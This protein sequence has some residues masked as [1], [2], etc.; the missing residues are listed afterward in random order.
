MAGE[1]NAVP[2]QLIP[3]A[4]TAMGLQGNHEGY[5]K[6]LLGVQDELQAAV[7]SPG[8]GNQIVAAM[9]DAHQ[10]GADLGRQLQEI[11]QT[12]LDTGIA[13]D[14]QDME[15]AARVLQATAFGIDGVAGNDAATGKVDLTW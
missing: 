11:I 4:K 12:L 5:L 15:N 3:S 2:D 6:A 7:K 9:T 10:A 1:L 14:V 13:V 8:A